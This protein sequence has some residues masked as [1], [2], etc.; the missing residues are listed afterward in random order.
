MMAK[1]PYAKWEPAEGGF[2]V[3]YP[4]CPC[5]EVCQCFAAGRRHAKVELYRMARALDAAG[6]PPEGCP[7]GCGGG[8]L[9]CSC[10]VSGYNAGLAAALAQA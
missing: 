5:G 7:G 10:Y 3:T 1:Q 2:L 6:G 8:P 4:I 9:A